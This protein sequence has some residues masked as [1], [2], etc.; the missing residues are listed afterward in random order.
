MTQ[1]LTYV[2]VKKMQSNGKIFKIYNNVNILKEVV[3]LY[4][5]QICSQTISL[6]FLVELVTNGY[7]HVHIQTLPLSLRLRVGNGKE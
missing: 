7:N 2:I 3:A 1:N 6:I 5:N 4:Y